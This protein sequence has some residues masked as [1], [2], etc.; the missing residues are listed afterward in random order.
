MASLDAS[1]SI[2]LGHLVQERAGR[3]DDLIAECLRKDFPNKD[4]QMALK[5]LSKAAQELGKRG[6]S[7]TAL[8]RESSTNA[9]HLAAIRKHLMRLCQALG[10]MH[11]LLEFLMAADV[12]A[13]PNGITSY[14]GRRIRQRFPDAAFSFHSTLMYNYYFYP[15]ARRL[16]TVFVPIN[17][18]FAM[19]KTYGVLGFP[20]AESH[21]PLNCLLLAHEAGHYLYR[22]LGC[23]AA[24]QKEAKASG[25]WDATEQVLSAGVSGP[26]G[27]MPMAGD[28]IGG[29]WACT[30]SWLEELAADRIAVYLAGP[31]FLLA[32]SD[33]AA[34]MTQ[35]SSN[36]HPSWPYR[37]DTL[38]LFMAL[39]S[40]GPHL[41]SAP[42]DAVF[43]SF[44]RPPANPAPTPSG[45]PTGPLEMALDSAIG[46]LQPLM[47]REVDGI[48]GGSA[49]SQQAADYASTS[50]EAF[51]LLDCGVPPGE[52][53]TADG[54]VPVPE[55]T[56][57][58]AA[59]TFLLTE[60]DV[61]WKRFSGGERPSNRRAAL[62]ALLN[63]HVEKALEISSLR[64]AWEAPR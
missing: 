40:W 4:I 12:Y 3:I 60:L 54:L 9:N 44:S 1:Q 35:R 52:V 43:Q 29:L 61:Q 6:A 51:R 41:Q 58:L 23:P 50:E 27:Q 14:L 33:L 46:L 55:P 15:L 42:L 19:K 22:A 17:V 32:A 5:S 10:T 57:L 56:I 37:L 8:S 28:P 39:S 7:L 63:D 11:E 25:V 49:L 62:R 53:R 45:G 34:T 59:W 64:R 13:L 16:E 36:D 31:A 24:V 26:S 47:E 48:F 38:Y 18:P 2:R 20:R 30:T 21:D